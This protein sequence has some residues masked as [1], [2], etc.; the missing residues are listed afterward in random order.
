MRFKLGLVLPALILGA[1]A[2]PVLRS[3]LVLHPRMAWQCGDPKYGPDLNILTMLTPVRP[4][5]VLSARVWI[6]AR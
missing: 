6:A 1:S 4:K 3:P 5:V 2:L